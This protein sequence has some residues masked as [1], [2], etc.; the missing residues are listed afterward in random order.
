VN[1]VRSWFFDLFLDCVKLQQVEKIFLEKY[2]CSVYHTILPVFSSLVI[3]R[4]FMIN[5]TK[6][7]ET[8]YGFRQHTRRMAR[9]AIPAAIILVISGI[10]IALAFANL[11]PQGLGTLI[12]FSALLGIGSITVLVPLIVFFYGYGKGGLWLDEA[13]VRVHYPGEPEQRMEW[14]EAL[15]AIDEGEE[16]LVSSKGKEGLGHLV[17]K[18][19]YVRLHLEGILSE[20]RAEI[21][22]AIAEH[23]EVRQPRQFTFTTFLNTKGETVARGRLYVFEKEIL[24]AENRGKKRVFINAPL[25]KLTW[26]KPRDIFSVGKSEFEAFAICYDKKEYVVMLGYEMTT[27]G[28][29]GTSSRWLATGSAQEWIETLQPVAR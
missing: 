5:T 2:P 23:V 20:Q 18:T 6:Q 21:L 13:G 3:K 12:A 24:C 14:S 15:Y 25:Q 8:R 17:S 10:I 4:G 19:Y 28:I 9:V 26:V 7:V 27:N 1:I 16:Y 22:R 11:L 29:F